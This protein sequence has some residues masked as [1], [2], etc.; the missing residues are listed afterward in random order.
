METKLST[1]IIKSSNSSM[2]S[3]S[4]MHD[5]FAK[6]LTKSLGED[7]EVLEFLKDK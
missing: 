4:E 5:N 2:D 7:K 1:K 3:K 6:L